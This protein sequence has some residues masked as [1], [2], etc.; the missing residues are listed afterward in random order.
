MTVAMLVAAIA[1]A[2]NFIFIGALRSKITEA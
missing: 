1:T 2:W